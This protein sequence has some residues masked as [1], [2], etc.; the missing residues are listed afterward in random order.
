M[1]VMVRPDLFMDD[2]INVIIALASPLVPAFVES[3]FI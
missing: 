2:P 3:G 1:S